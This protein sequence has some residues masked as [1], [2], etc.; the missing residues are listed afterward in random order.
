MMEI[1]NHL[2]GLTT[3]MIGAVIDTDKEAHIG[4]DK[5]G[6]RERSCDSKE[7]ILHRP[8]CQNPVVAVLRRWT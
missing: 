8:S 2:S 7:Y 4:L 6:A 1:T 5:S 3:G